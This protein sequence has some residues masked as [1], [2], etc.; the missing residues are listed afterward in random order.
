MGIKAV[1]FDLDGTLIDTAPDFVVV[2][3][4]LLLE[5]NREPLP[6]TPIRNTVSHGARALVTLGFGL[7]EGDTG[8]EDLRLR[9]L[10]LY[11]QHLAD[12]SKPFD[13]ITELLDWFSARDIAWGIATNKPEVYARPLIKALQLEP[14]NDCIICP[15]N[16]S[17]RKPHPESLY[18]AGQLLNC[19]PQEIIYVGDHERDIACGRNAGSPTIA[20]AYGYIENADKINNWQADHI[21]NHAGE[22]QAIITEYL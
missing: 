17:E 16:V 19:A 6:A 1:V 3:N 2:L 4:K 13:G 22:L 12:T 21:V 7:E 15:D 8:Y 11:S 14:S 18:L 5:N 10:E 9:L 20:C